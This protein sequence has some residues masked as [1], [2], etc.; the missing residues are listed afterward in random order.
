MYNL[1]K[2]SNNDIL[3]ITMN[4]MKKKPATVNQATKFKDG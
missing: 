4:K 1:V 2:L 3:F